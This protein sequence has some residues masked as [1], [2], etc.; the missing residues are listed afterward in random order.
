MAAMV[1]INLR[2]T[3]GIVSSHEVAAGKDAPVVIAV[4]HRG[5]YNIEL[6]DETTGH[7]PQ[8][9]TTKRVGNN[10][11][12][13]FEGGDA[14]APDVILE[15]YYDNDSVHLIGQ[16]E[17]GQYYEYIPTSG[18]VA[19]YPPA[20]LDGQNSQVVLGGEGS[21]IAD[22]V[23]DGD[24]FAWL[25]FLLLGAATAGVAG[26]AWAASNNHNGG[27][28]S[29]S[30]KLN[31]TI[32]PP[33]DE[34]KDGRP[35][36][37]G[38]SSSPNAD[39]T[40]TLPDGSTLT[41]KTDK[42]GN[43]AIE[44]PASQPNGAI[45]VTVTD[46]SGNTG[47]ANI[48][49]R[50]ETAPE[51]PSITQND[52]NGLAG[53]AE[54]GAKV[55]ITD[56]DSGE[57]TT[58]TADENGDW[59]IQPNPINKGDNT[60]TVVAEDPAGNVSPPLIVN[61][62]VADIVSGSISLTD[63]VA[64]VTGVIADGGVTNDTRPTYSGKATPGTDHVNIY[65][66]GELIGSAP[67]DKDG[68]WRF[69]PA[70]SLA[71][72]S[73]H[74]Y[75]VAAVEA[76]GKE[77]AH[78]SGTADD[79]W[80]F[81]IDSIAP[82]N[83]T[84][85]IVD[86]SL[87]L[88]DD[89]GPVTGPILD[90]G[91]T[92]DTRPTFSGKA[93]DDIDHVNIYDNGELIGSAP[94]DENGN[95]S[96]T[97][98]TDLAEGDHSLSASAVDKAGNEGPQ[99]GGADAGWD[100]T[101][102]TSAPDNTTSG[103]VDGSLSLTDDVG[104][105]TGP[106]P[107][108]GN[109]DD[110]RPTFSGKATSDI[111]HVN[112]Y[113][114]GE[115][116]GS[117][118]VDKDGNW[119]FTPET[120]LAAGDHAF[121][122]AAVDKAG[123]EGAQISGTNDESWD[124]TLDVTA[125]DNS[126]SG[127]VDGSLS[128]T[129]DVGPVTGPITDGG[130]TD[131]ARPTFSGKATDDIDRVNIYDKGTL[132][133]SAPVDENG[134]WSFTPETDL[135]EGDHSLSA[136]AVDKAG[137]EGAPVSGTDD[138][139]WDFTV[140]TSAPDNNTSGI[141]SGSL[142]LTDDVG[143]VTGP[144]TDGG[145]TDDARPTFSGKATSDIDHVNIYDK[146]TLIGSAPVDKD[147]NWSFTPETDLAEGEHAFTAAAVDKAGNEGAPVSGTDDESWDFTLDV[148]A[149][150]NST[151]GIVDG[152][153]SLTD[154][155]GAVTGPITDGGVTDDARPTF[156][157]KATS[158][159]DH[160]NIYDKGTLIG[161]APVDE[162]G[163]WSFT[164]ETD[165]AE[166]EH[167]LTAAAVDKAGNEGAPVSGTDDESWDFTLNITAPDTGVF[168][169]GSISLTDDVVPVTG[170]ITDGSSTNDA[171]P[172]YAGTITA[173]GLAGG[174]VSVNI[175]D[176]GTLIGNA[177]VDQTSGAWSFTPETDLTEGNHA[178]TVAA[179]DRAGNVGAQI[180]G[181]NDESW[182]FTLD[183]TV[184]DNSTS[185][186]VDDSLSLTDDVGPV[187]GPIPDG[188][189]TDDAR[190]TFSGKAT[191]D[192]DHV[193]IYD[194]GT[195]I[196]SA[197]VDE[198]G[199]WS[200][201][202]G[203]DLAEG[204]HSL[205][206]AAV[207]KAG[208]EG[209]RVSGTDD[210]SW[211]FTLDVT[212]PDNSTSG[213]VDGSLSLTDDVGPV[214]GPILD[215]G[216][217][218]DARP[219][220]SG[221]ATDDIDHVNIYDNGELI[222][223]APVDENGNWSF[224]P[225]TD[226][227]EGEHSLSAAAVDK[228]GNEGAPV[229]GTDD[230]NWDFTVDTSAPDNNTS[231][232]VDGSL[233]LTD[234]VGAVTGPIT[235]GG[236]TDD[237]RPTFSGKATSDI[238]HVNI[239]DKGT[240]IGSAPVDENGNWSFTPETDLAEGDHAF[241]AAAVDKA[242]NEGPQT[243][244]ADDS[245][246]FTVDITAPD[247]EAF[248]NDSVTL[249][250]NVGPVQ[251]NINDGDTTDDAQPTYAGRI[252]ADALAEGVASVNIY[253]HGELI[254]NVPV[255]QET[256]TW[257]F[258][259][260]K[261]L[262]SGDHSLTVAAVDAAGNV[263]PQISGTEDEAWDFT[264]LTSAPAQ[265]SIENIR[266]DFTQG[267]DDDTG[268]LQK[269]QVTN[270]ATLTVNG[271]AGPG[272]TVQVWA[273]DSSNN[274]VQVGEGKVDKDGRWSITISEL[275]ADGSYTL[276]ATA[277]NAA[278][279]SSAETGGFPIVL[280]TAAPDA[281][282][283]TLMDDE[284]DKQG[285]ISPGGVTDDRSPVLTGTGEAGATV[286]VYL[287]GADAPVGSVVVNAQ[288][289]W[290]LPLGTLT[291]GEHS[292]Q[293]K[294]TDAAGNETRG[295]AVTFTVDSSAVALT[296]DQANDD[297]GSITGAV[298]NNGLTDDSSPELQGSATPGATVTIK[299][300][301]GSVL[302]TV[303]ADAM[304]VWRFQLENVPDG[305]H[306]WTAETTNAA[307]NTAQATITLTI[308]STPPAPPVIT[309]L[310]DD[311]GTVQ[312]TSNVQ[313]NVTDDPA[314]TLTGTA[315]AGA[316]VTL[317]DGSNVL[318][319]VTANAE[320]CW[321][322]TPTTNLT[323]GTHSITATATDAAGNVS[324]PSASWNFVLDITAPNVGIS[325]NSTESLSGQSEPGVLITV[326]TANGEKFTAVADQN[327]R[328]IMTPNPVAAGESGKIYATDPA[329]NVGDPLSFQGSALASYDLLNE[330]EQVNTTTA[331]DQLN[332]STTR[333]A[334]GR[335]VVTWQG[336][337]SGSDVFMQLYEADGVHKIGTEQLVNQRTG[338]NQDSPQVVALADGGFLIVYESYGGGL[339]NSGDGVI[340]RRY[341]ADG[342]AMTDEF[343]VNATTVGSQRM[344][345]AV[346]TADG[347]YIITWE[348]ESKVIYQRRYDADNQPGDE[349]AVLTGTS[350][351]TS[352]GP[353]MAAFTDAAH[354]GMYITVWSAAGGPSDSN[355]TGVV[356]QI[357]G[358][359]GQ[360][361]GN[362]FQV[363]TTMDASQNYP[364]V[365]TLTDGSFVVYWDT[366]DSGANGSDIRAVHYRVDAE[367]G[368]VS[369][370]G[371]GDFIVNSYTAGK[372][373]KPV[374]V[375]LED[376]GYLIIWGSDGGDG[377]GSAVYAQRYDADDH[378]VGRE[379]IVNTTTKG[380]QGTGGDSTDATHILDATLTAD[381]N[382][383]VTW[384]SDN[385]DGSGNGVEG[386]V[387]NPDAAYYSEFTVN[388]TTTGAQTV[389]SV[390]SLPGGGSV[391]VWQSASGD[392]SGSCVMGQ[393]LD[394]KGQPVGREFI[395]NT[396]T[397]GDQTV[398][399][400]AV[401][402]DGSF[403][404]VWVSGGYIKGQ[405]FTY[406]HDSDGA[407]NGVTTSG[408]EF[409]V[410]SG[411][412][413]SSQGHPVITPL[414]D[415]GYMV[416]WQAA[417]DNVWQ[418]YGRQYDADGSPV[419]DQQILSSTSLSVSGILGVGADWEPLPS[420]TTLSNG[421][422]AITYTKKGNGYDTAVK[423][424]D[425]TTHTVGTEFIANQTVTNNQASPS[426]SAL[427]N[428]N[429]VVTWDSNDKSGPDQN[430]YS[431]WGRI[432]DAEGK[433]V[434]NEFIINT[435]TAG[436]QHLAKVASR[437]DGSFVIVFVSATDADAGAGTYGIYA[438]Y[439]DASGA[440]VGQQMRINQLTY[441]DQTEVDVTF[442]EGGQLY[443]TWTDAGVGD[444]SGSAI[445]GRIVDL[446][447][448]LGLEEQTP[449]NDDPTLIDYQPSTVSTQTG[450][451]NIP[452]NVG[453]STNTAEKLGGQTEPGVTVTVTD[454]KG[455]EHTVIADDKGAWSIEPNPLNVGDNGYI[456]VSDLAGNTSVPI[457]ISGSA[458]DSYDLLNE[459]AQVNTTTAG[460]Q[461]NPSTT[462]LADGRIVV[463]W[464]GAGSGSD[465][466]MQLYEAD[467]VHKIG[468]E[469]L[470]N[471][472]TGGNQDSPQVVALADGGFLIV[473]E[474]YG[475]GLD[476]SGDGVI[477]RRYG[478]DG[479]A[480]TDEFLVN[481]TTVGSQRMPSAVATADGG[482][483]ITWESESKVIYQRRYD[484][485][486]QPGD[487]VAVLTGTSVGTSG[488]PEMAAFTDAA[489]QGMYIT[490]WS[491]AG[492]PSDSN[493]TGVVGQI[494]GADG[495][496]LG[497]AF[498]VNT[499]MDASQN[500]PDVITLADGSFVV[501]WDTDDSG[502]N[503]SDIRA[504]HYRVDAETGS[505]SVVGTGDFI[506]N[507]YTA[508]KQYKPVGVALEDGGYLIIWG[509]DG[510]DGSGSAVY[511][512]RYDADDHKVGREFIVNTTT[513]G[514]QGTGGDSIDATHILDATLTADGNVY[515]TW[516]SDNVDGS[517]N[518]VEGI[519][520]N[521]DAA[522]YSEFAVNTTTTGDQTAS[523]VVSLPT[524]GLFEVWVSASGDGSGT[525][526]KGQMLDAKGQPVGSEFTV[527]STTTGN[528]LTPVVLENGNIEVVWTSP[529]TNGA[530]YIKGQ[531]YSYSYDKEGNINGLTPVGGEFNISSGAGATGQ[532]HPDV[533]SL[534]DGGYI[535]VWEA[536]V[537]GEYK[538]FARQYDADNS[539]ATGEIVL[540]STGL[541]TGILGNSNS[542]SALPSI[543]QLSNGQIAV[544]YAVKGTSYDTSVVMYDP[545]THV[546]SSSS[547]VNQ[548]T[549]GDQASATVSALDNGNFVV[550]WD[551]NDNSGP[552]Q[553][554]YSV[555]GRLYD[556]S[557][558]ALSNEFIINTDT[559][560][561]QHLPKVVSRA[562]GSFVAL[563]VS[564]TDGDAG[565][566][567]YG[568]YAQYFDAAGHK[569]GQQIQINQL[570]FGDQTE[571]DA[572]FTEG[573]QLY[574]TWTDSGVGDGS[575]SAIKG[576]LV[577]LVETLGL[578]D[579]GTGV[580]HIDYRPAQHYLNGTDGNDSLDGRGAIAI[581]GKGGDDTIFIN[582]T[583]FS[584]INGGDGND[585]LVWDSNNNFE[586]GSVSSKISGIETIH[587]G[588]NAAQTLV[589]S[590]SDI[591]EMT[592]DNGE[593]E[594]V[595][596]ITGDDGD[597]N[598][599]GARD[600]VSINK[601]VWTASSS[602]TE[603]GVTYDVYVHNDDA[604]VNLMIQHGLNVV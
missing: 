371:T 493:S 252:T 160:V 89:V 38:T 421:K 328:W 177:A 576:R 505:V 221:K 225:E 102:D 265:P 14:D 548:T 29:A 123:N 495:Q 297:V 601:S 596:K 144:I 318:G 228:A 489:H 585:T 163:N 10:L 448:T 97:P 45:T 506:V 405:K 259:P 39:V 379:F 201:T 306:T 530:N 559:A 126:T 77:G 27:S 396:T 422:V 345:S 444:G 269:G 569:V 87:S 517:G 41:T 519:V 231:G 266:D 288:G 478:A 469:Q 141:V 334:D 592:K 276:T 180:S 325:G 367:T 227:A 480:M 199:N 317:Y 523:K 397:T 248:E 185:G 220:F 42:D 216:F 358:A 263:G 372:Q 155:V 194:K 169:G 454:A 18:E 377:S 12:L 322:Y 499:T 300:E 187:T 465:V 79:G 40:I 549:S 341:G 564:A 249:T 566:G 314:P 47:T 319:V 179:V 441:G 439:F 435:V 196:G 171:R 603:N 521:P 527:N 7:A 289:N 449:Q 550:T 270:D 352:G 350:V 522:Y 226:L 46:S 390:S 80:S 556:G 96:F 273:T 28:H 166:G 68:N 574:V 459:S 24:N 343:L 5:K 501:Y 15:D 188:G 533:T 494:F 384:Q 538:I 443:V 57:T 275:G 507:S 511:A 305:V 60:A 153:L 242:G 292:Y 554:G 496:P 311:V 423:I 121:T 207:D 165:L 127:I 366:D 401:L 389:S 53:K 31:V 183:V 316:I 32:N 238:D 301:D 230:G 386:I 464:Q 373:Y 272:M 525:A 30:P 502:A 558:K 51:T 189:V 471:Q 253:D 451:D 118:P 562:D 555:W 200:F 335:I 426:V 388:S 513:K 243:G 331:G 452:P 347:G 110:A 209:A 251:G 577:D 170:V 287:D 487:E 8:L 418:I 159:I 512:Q 198:N 50:D 280:D 579:D 233:S 429:F 404:V 139:S 327:G 370:V 95:W 520:I 542:W 76:A 324:A 374:G 578:P 534:D 192:I 274:R 254:G 93:T 85:G 383:Y 593:S 304:G 539:P 488:G 432:Y 59:S 295:E 531:Q 197:P 174:V 476:N 235:D 131:D 557:G 391:V 115:L 455:V 466:F 167:S 83:N 290:T 474:S 310:E 25:P 106:I 195:L 37:S 55:T 414:S 61:R 286:S 412:G 415:G 44:A 526:I 518:G 206:A 402:T 72:G 203:T 400:V 186:I 492:G 541:T 136:A 453:I 62:P 528:Q 434:S 484:A 124:F 211:D 143:P 461:L 354:Q 157:G 64:P 570:N 267:E 303:E 98:E 349:V 321:S 49:Y 6:I 63:D 587:M 368:S 312:F 403:E 477:A 299:D 260:G 572:T 590:A 428:G 380:N 237:A 353:E 16:A 70:K 586:L 279:V 241:T 470:V 104:P 456:S 120:D 490:V 111:D 563:F 407:I 510:G 285:A 65:D 410:N 515:V 296:I 445:K 48:D 446:V 584:S 573:G 19:D 75:T 600:T 162:N 537:G 514:N 375:A 117:A 409:N 430:G 302:G 90:G 67:V 56:K 261:S 575:G 398:P 308:D 69:T 184:P 23:A 156:S 133:G 229:S 357:F 595:L 101:V 337:G 532:Q 473:Y 582:S 340:A 424:Y 134:N 282:V 33:T 602:E 560:G 516:Q 283:A 333:L 107:D 536:L 544:T 66:N 442:L 567:T 271:T 140:D 43:W 256:G 158:D 58:V 329:G 309:S 17:N 406:S 540:A 450:E 332:P 339:D 35:E 399:Q 232:I 395:V 440:R 588:N 246:D 20:M 22:P 112:I 11:V 142:S 217:T 348:S 247:A 545:A 364:D 258:T 604:T 277:V 172:T 355:S 360:P 151:S 568:I 210:E 99:T 236:I 504:V 4:P 307:Q 34:D 509:S 149:P 486:N 129:D 152:S 482:Y 284:G 190:P 191:S 13:A 71:E 378:K 178:F 84:S 346:A 498:Q 581:D 234:D 580:T 551:S 313:G 326:E 356:G 181:T 82:D 113:D 125:P 387:I 344:P 100:F 500:Y 524:G 219:T 215:G 148:T 472:R 268:Y 529:G 463:T 447:E 385:V 81:T 293:T 571:V 503:G 362:A 278:G 264:L 122:V 330:S 589:I 21:T 438:Q 108:G 3:K 204:E 462:R 109:I 483:I 393:M 1:K 147:G 419:A 553:S 336:A 417:V 168:A 591:L 205:S 479:G 535:V 164:P 291:D 437:P 485:D 146:G 475:G 408:A 546:V 594:H 257:S 413:A 425:P 78:I 52:D 202:P 214:T 262:A 9:V 223:S 583:A 458:L 74:N 416:V 94:V 382:V 36:L 2:G 132:I 154:D 105:V 239:Y 173:E 467:G 224:T 561:N 491:A 130:I 597:S 145:I 351:G 212:A 365:I 376:G 240:L 116:I 138:G 392:G 457:L 193:N 294:I 420:V 598:T 119:S 363:N 255:D 26:V 468:T 552:D 161:S 361:L 460:D 245:W 244:G 182:D 394:A 359:D 222:G 175:Y 86:G 135:A 176:K 323:E 73:S 497:N 565:P 315:E 599:N 431:V 547:I 298:L 427:D 250:D 342:G 128:L 508:G 320:G 369:V 92:D 114:N 218:D 91:V 137:N 281:A 436:D 433:A 213:I 543:A 54:P 411:T 103:I 381:G 208:N 481:A 338:G 88:T 150:D